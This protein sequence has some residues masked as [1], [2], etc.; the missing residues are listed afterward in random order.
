MILKLVSEKKTTAAWIL[1]SL[2]PGDV[3]AHGFYPG[4]GIGG[5]LH[6]DADENWTD[7]NTPPGYN[8]FVVAVQEIGHCLG[9][10]HSQS[11]DSVMYPTFKN[12]WSIKQSH[13]NHKNYHKKNYHN[14][15]N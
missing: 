15:Q 14:Y 6:F 12:E 10:S 4:P 9:L 13:N 2:E 8:L 11:T 1:L 5:D 7:Q 3:L